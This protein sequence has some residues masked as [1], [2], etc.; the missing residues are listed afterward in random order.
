VL[1]AVGTAEDLWL[2]VALAVLGSLAC[3]L[4]LRGPVA[5]TLRR[6]ARA[7]LPGGGLD[8]DRGGWGVVLADRPYL[9]ITASYT[10]LTFAWLLLGLALPM[11]LVSALGLPPW[12]PSAALALNTGLTVLLQQRVTARLQGWRRTRAILLGTGAFV[13]AFTLLGLVAVVPELSPD[14]TT[15]LVIV[16]AVLLVAVALYA[17]G[18]MAVGPAASALAVELSPVALRGRYSA[19]FQTSWTLSGVTGPVAIGLLLTWSSTGLWVV[20]GA[21]VALGGL[22]FW[23]SERWLPVSATGRPRSFAEYG[24]L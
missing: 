11:Y 14:A 18:E 9:A 4:V 13:V 15:G 20:M 12:L 23:L 8:A 19:L 10:A 22:G 3:A 2:L 24:Q 7:P 6:A 21:V 5:R 17:L 1:L 16:A